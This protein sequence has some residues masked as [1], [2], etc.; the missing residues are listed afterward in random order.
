MWRDAL[1]SD[2][3]LVNETASLGV[4]DAADYDAWKA[5]FGAM[6]GGGSASR[7]VPDPGFFAVPEPVSLA[8]TG[9]GILIGGAMLRWRR[10]R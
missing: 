5:N 10:T 3:P 4:V 2:T 8:L 1:Y 7:V 6:S 9:V